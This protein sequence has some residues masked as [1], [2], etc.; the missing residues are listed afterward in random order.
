MEII[1]EREKEGTGFIGLQSVV[2]YTKNQSIIG[3]QRPL[4]KEEAKKGKKK[5]KN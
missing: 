4:M 5:K 1:L 3:K 2:K